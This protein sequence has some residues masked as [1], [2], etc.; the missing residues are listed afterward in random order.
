M[1]HFVLIRCVWRRATQRTCRSWTSA[2]IQRLVTE[3]LSCS[4]RVLLTNAFSSGDS[5]KN[6]SFGI[7]ITFLTSS[8][9][10]TCLQSLLP[11]TNSAISRTKCYLSDKKWLK[12]A[13]R[14]KT[15]KRVLSNSNCPIS[16]AEKHTIDTIISYT[17]TMKI[18]CTWLDAISSCSRVTSSMICKHSP[19]L[20]TTL[21]NPPVLCVSPFHFL[22]DWFIDRDNLI[23]ENGLLG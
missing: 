5:R 6:L 3:N 20:T 4:H 15:P 16:L 7:S 23:I 14:S 10:L 22:L 19:R 8:S 1:L 12:H 18:Y 9:N 21:P 17:I 11:K 2:R 13:H